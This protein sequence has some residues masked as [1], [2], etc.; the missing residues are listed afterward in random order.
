MARVT[1][2]A[3]QLHRKVTIH[4]R[5]APEVG[6]AIRAGVDWVMH[7]NLMTD[8][9]IEQLAESKIPLCPTL[10]LHANWSQYGS[11]FGVP[12]PIK[13][14]TKRML[15]RSAETL[16][17]AH[18]AGVRFMVGTDTGFSATPFG[19]WHAR[20]LRVAGG[21]RRLSTLEAIQAGTE[22]SA[23][24]VNGEGR[25]GAIAAGMAADVLVVDGDPVAD[26]RVLQDRRRLSAII[27]RG[28]IWTGNRGDISSWPVDRAQIFSTEVLAYDLVHGQAR[29]REKGRF[30][31]GRSA[32]RARSSEPAHRVRTVPRD[33]ADLRRKPRG[34][35]F[36]LARGK[37]N[38]TVGGAAVI[39]M[40]AAA[41]GSSGGGGSVASHEVL[42]FDVA[43]AFTGS[44]AP[45]GPETMAGCIPAVRL[46]NAAG[47]VLGHKVRCSSTNTEGDPADAVPAIDKMLAT[48]SGVVGVLGPSSDEASAVVPILNAASIPMFPVT[49]QPSFDK[50]TYQYFWRT[51]PADDQLGYAMAA[52]GKLKGY[53]SA[54]AFFGN[55]VGA[56][57]QVPGLVSGYKRLGLTISPDLAIAY[58]QP[59]YRS[60]IEQILSA[61]PQAIFEELDPQTG[62]TFMSEL[63]N[64]ETT[65][66]P[67]V[68]DS[69]TLEPSWIHAVSEGIGA[70]TL[71]NECVAI[72]PYA[73]PVVP[74][75]RRTT[76][77]CS[78][79]L[80]R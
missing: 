77:P 20:E 67:I 34:M 37:H 69:V 31:C 28:A 70:T 21:I 44:D 13:E 18:Q 62:A 42:T 60:E 3:H 76:V 15:E 75:G 56:Q 43:I 33:H 52:W 50:S 26:I 19:E 59:S 36:M 78:L 66:I 32:E 27:S 22:G 46:I 5:G 58:D 72:Q 17:K 71:K 65:A 48:S 68:G 14:G 29:R 35:I 57:A 4:A 6:A 8:E 16:H 23:L 80:P 7:G 39:A 53:T 11:L 41:C 63:K 24:A 55:S 38:A 9:V 1:E 54:A 2:V 40:L 10:L 79:P 64:L 47:G 51:L 45:F 61:H 12:R 73:P 49:G 30:R 25:V 74:A